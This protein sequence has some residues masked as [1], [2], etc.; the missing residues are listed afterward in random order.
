MGSAGATILPTN[1][2][3][4]QSAWQGRY[5]DGNHAHDHSCTLPK[6]GGSPPGGSQ[7]KDVEATL[8]VVLSPYQSRSQRQLENLLKQLQEYRKTCKDVK[9]ELYGLCRAHHLAPKAAMQFE[10]SGGSV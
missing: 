2:S 6:R 7:Q 5:T 4:W 1:Q 8:I 3:P 9:R 10:S